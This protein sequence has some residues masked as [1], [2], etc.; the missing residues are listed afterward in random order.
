MRTKSSKYMEP[1]PESF[2]LLSKAITLCSCGVPA[3]KDRT[4]SY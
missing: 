1:S 2:V 3:L 4:L